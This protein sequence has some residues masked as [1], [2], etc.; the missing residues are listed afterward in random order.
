MNKKT[1]SKIEEQHKIIDKELEAVEVTLPTPPPE[2][3]APPVEPGE[4]RLRR[5]IG[6]LQ[7]KLEIA[8]NERHELRRVLRDLVN[9][10]RGKSIDVMEAKAVLEGPN[11]DNGPGHPMSI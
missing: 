1:R 3:P 9:R 11:R 2:P 6:D 10:C 7:R 5:T 4:R 8:G